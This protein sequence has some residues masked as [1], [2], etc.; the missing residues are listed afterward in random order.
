MITAATFVE[1]AITA[2]RDLATGSALDDAALVKFLDENGK[3]L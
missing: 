3:L 2:V 1:A